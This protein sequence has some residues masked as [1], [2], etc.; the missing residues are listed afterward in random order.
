MIRIL[1]LGA[2]V[3]SSAVLLMSIRGALPRLD[4]AI[5]AD[6]QW[7]PAEVYDQLAFLIAEGAKAGIPVHVVTAGNLRQHVLDAAEG[8]TARCSKPPMYARNEDGQPGPLGRDCSRD[9]KV[10]VIERKA[11]E[12]AGLTPGRPLPK[13]VVVEQWLGISSDEIQ[14][15]KAST[16]PWLRIWHP[17][18]EAP[19]TDSAALRDD[20]MTRDD[21]ARWM[22]DNGFP[23]AP[24]SA[25][26]GCPYHS[27]AAWRAIRAR[28]EQWADVCDFDRRAR[29]IPGVK[30]QG[31]A[32]LHRSLVPLERAPIDRDE[33]GQQTLECSAGCFL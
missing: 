8:R 31:G 9:F 12:L 21:C 16:E 26:I 3:Q 19:W 2:G 33:P 32:Y 5:F 13:A 18:I 15:M 14:R 24:K 11:K 4:A 7:E 10:R 1:S 20:A 6:T 23:P 17:L 25:C 28:P 29:T 22:A 30:G 27:D